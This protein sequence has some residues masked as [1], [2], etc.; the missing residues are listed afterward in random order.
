MQIG[1]KQIHI[2]NF[3]GIKEL[4]IDFGQV[5]NIK[6]DN[7]KG[8]STIFDAFCWV[9]FGK[10]SHGNSKF[11]I[12]PIDTTGKDIDYIDIQVELKVLVNGAEITIKKVQKQKWTKKRGSEDKVFD[13]N[14]NEFEWNGF[15]KTEKEFNVSIADIVSDAVFMIVTNPFFFPNQDWKKQRQVLMQLIPEITDADVYMTDTRFEEV[16][17]PL[18]VNCTS[19]DL[20][21]K[22]AKAFKEWNK[23]IDAIP[24]RIDEVSRTIKDI[25]FIEQEKQLAILQTSLESINAKIEDESKA[26]EVV[27]KL[28]QEIFK[29]RSK[30]QD[31]E[32][33]EKQK[34]SAARATVQSEIDTYNREF[35]SFMETVT[36][37]N[38]LI[39]REN[40]LLQNNQDNL[41]KTRNDFKEQDEKQFDETT[42]FCPVC[43]QEYPECQKEEMRKEF[44]EHK[45]KELTKIRELG[46][47]LK[48]SVESSKRN[49]ATLEEE[50]KAAIEKKTNVFT[51]LNGKRKE[52]EAIP[53]ECDLITNEEYSSLKAKLEVLEQEKSNCGN[54][55]DVTVILK[56]ERSEIQKQI[57]EVKKV[58]NDKQHM[59]DAKNRVIELKQEQKELIQKV[60][61]AEKVIFLIE[62]FMRAKMDLLSNAINSKF[63]LVNWKLFDMQINGGMKETCELTLNGIP[64]SDLNSAGKTQAGLDIINTLSNI[65][66]VNAP[67]FIDNREGVNLIPEMKS[68]VINLIVS[69]DKEIKVEVEA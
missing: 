63:K 44:Q 47:N 62:E 40:I 7:A 25:N 68:Q 59:D 2:S 61:D 31:I 53:L 39:E 41:N 65:Y 18:L 30:I 56:Q 15:P 54:G 9:L 64:Y 14:Y 4:T 20:K 51:L 19:D 58:L 26:Y 37:L 10:D 42:L 21:A 24:G 6:A 50:V 66:E 49:I 32:Y 29:T 69:K 67:I 22:Y 60:A 36:N 34:I 8:K 46:H 35:N 17:R 23:Q 57:D 28:N 43:G 45:T 3:K 27:N 33:K 16:L 55:T 13:G 38:K 12:R 48:N 52:L 11:H 5:T 1:L